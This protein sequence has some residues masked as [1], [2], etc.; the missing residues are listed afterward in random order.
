MFSTLGEMGV[1]DRCHSFISDCRRD[2]D[3]NT[4]PPTT[5]SGNISGEECIDENERSHS[6][7]C[8]CRSGEGENSMFSIRFNAYTPGIVGVA[9]RLT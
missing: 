2:E 3:E 5:S 7:I 8:D 4:T 1:K 6:S 9:G